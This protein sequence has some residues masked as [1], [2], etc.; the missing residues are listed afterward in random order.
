MRCVFEFQYDE[1]NGLKHYRCVTC[2]QRVS[3]K[4]SPE[5]ITGDCGETP[6][7]S[8]SPGP[9]TILQI[10]LWVLRLKERKS[11]LCSSLAEVM[12]AMGGK[13]CWQNRKSII[14]LMY[15]EA[16]KRNLKIP[17]SNLTGSLLILVAVGVSAVLTVR[18]RKR[19][20]Y[21]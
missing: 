14:G 15:R 9:G 1:P 4:Y 19:H 11:C 12:N 18:L 20:S 8:P 6:S 21:A 5:M 13:W 2:W 10:L 17:V 7:Y 3:S 16:K